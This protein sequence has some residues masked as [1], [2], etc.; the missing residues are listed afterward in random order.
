MGTYNVVSRDAALKLTTNCNHR[1][2]SIVAALHCM[3]KL[4]C[5]HT[6]SIETAERDQERLGQPVDTGIIERIREAMERAAGY[7]AVKS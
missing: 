1:H 6:S 5:D 7:S 2:R 3:D 4:P